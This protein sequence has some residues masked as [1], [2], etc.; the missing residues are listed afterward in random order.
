MARAASGQL[1]RQSPTAEG[2]WAP[3]MAW[4]LCSD[5]E[6]VPLPGP[7]RIRADLKMDFE[8]HSNRSLLLESFQSKKGGNNEM[9]AIFTPSPRDTLPAELPSA[10]SLSPVGPA[11]PRLMGKE[12]NG[13]LSFCMATELFPAWCWACWEK[14][15]ACQRELESNLSGHKR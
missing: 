5:A 15:G 6:T 2:R 12:E 13:A 10:E 4:Q 11:R 14:A 7:N 1:C 9:S 3:S 8:N